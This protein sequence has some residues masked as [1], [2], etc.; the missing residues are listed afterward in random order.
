MR[1]ASLDVIENHVK[2]LVENYGMN[3][4][5][6]YDDQLLLNMSRAKDFFRRMAKYNL[7]IETPNG[8]TVVYI[9]EEMAQLMKQAGMDTI[10]LAIEH[11][12]D[13]MLRNVINKPLRLDKV[14]PVVGYLHKNNLFVQGFFV[15]GLPGERPQDRTEA[16]QFIKDV[17]LDWSG[18]S[19]A[20]PI[21]GSELYRICLENKYIPAKLP[22]GDYE[23]GT[24]IIRAPGLD[25]ATLPLESYR[26]NLDVNFINNR[27]MKLGEFD[28]AAR[29]FEDVIGRYD[30]HAFAFYFLSK[31]YDHLPGE[32]QKAKESMAKFNEIISTDEDWMGHAKYFGLVQ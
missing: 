19:L 25:P 18:F 31:C 22:I 24:Y 2:H 20:S 21:R 23:I 7:R 11:G 29:C 9:D 13:H 12:T 8:L 17:G 27:R 32:E 5:T 10:Q 6:I 26:M 28:V 16:T 15:I 14:A 30:N 1:Y 3:V 4:L